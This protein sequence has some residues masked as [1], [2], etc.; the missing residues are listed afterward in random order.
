MFESTL[1][2]AE[3]RRYTQ[4][5]SVAIGSNRADSRVNSHRR[6]FFPPMLIRGSIAKN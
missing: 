2:L 3:L 6:P 4:Q 1:D 5:H